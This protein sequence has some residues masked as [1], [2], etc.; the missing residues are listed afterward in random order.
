MLEPLVTEL[1]SSH[2]AANDMLASGVLDVKSGGSLDDAD[3]VLNNH[4][5]QLGARLR[6]RQRK[7]RTGAGGGDTTRLP[8]R[9]A[10]AAL[11]ARTRLRASTCRRRA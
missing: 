8:C 11:A 3:A 10:R 9:G 2:V 1:A 6:R 7:A 4:L 5:D